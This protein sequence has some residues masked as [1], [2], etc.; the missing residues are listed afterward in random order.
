MI[1]ALALAKRLHGDQVDAAGQPYWKHCQRVMLNLDCSWPLGPEVLQAAALHDVLEDTGTKAND[2]SC[3][4]VYDRAIK[5]IV[6]VTRSAYPSQLPY[7]D[8]IRELAASGVRDII[9]VK[10]A[11]VLD[12]GDPLRMPRPLNW[13]ERIATRYG[14][15]RAILEEALRRG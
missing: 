13:E 15:A 1:D 5:I 10:L 8:W 7:L 4:G 6:R 12:N 3:F 11:D 9:R 14:P 2:L